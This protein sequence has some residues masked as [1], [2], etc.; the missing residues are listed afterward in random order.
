MKQEQIWDLLGCGVNV[1]RCS[2][3]HATVE[4]GSITR[5]SMGVLIGKI[6]EFSLKWIKKH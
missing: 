2:Y 1:E 4:G 3:K 5:G 6:L